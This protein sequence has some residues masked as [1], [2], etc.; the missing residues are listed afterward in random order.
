MILFALRRIALLL[1]MVSPLCRAASIPNFKSAKTNANAANRN[2][3]MGEIKS[4][5]QERYDTSEPL[6]RL[7]SSII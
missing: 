7:R 5:A 4:A 3:R 1:R 6:M 2:Q